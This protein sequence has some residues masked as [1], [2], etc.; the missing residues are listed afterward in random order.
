MNCLQV[1]ET[2]LVC[3]G[4]PKVLQSRR[5]REK[6]RWVEEAITAKEYSQPPETGRAQGKAAP[7]EIRSAVPPILTSAIGAHV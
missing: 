1:R 7:P 3:L 2:I 4:G 6:R 5:G